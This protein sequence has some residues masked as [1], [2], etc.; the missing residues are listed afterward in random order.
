[1]RSKRTSMQCARRS[2]IS[3][4]THPP[5]TPHWPRY[6]GFSARCTTNWYPSFK[7][8]DK[9]QQEE[10]RYKKVYEISPKTPYQR[11]LESPEVSKECKA[12]LR[13]RKALY[14]PVVLNRRLNEAVE[15]ILRLNREKVYAE[16]ASCQTPAA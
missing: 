3:V 4:S 5:N 10:R 6:T 16:N 12:E 9:V 1:M 15:E 13:R 2:A 11:L 7:L 8:I 14:N